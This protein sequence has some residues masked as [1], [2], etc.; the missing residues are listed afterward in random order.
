[1]TKFNKE[2]SDMM[3]LKK[4]FSEQ[5]D[6]KRNRNMMEIQNDQGLSD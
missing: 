6:L 5:I 4:V 1:M 2:I 3:R